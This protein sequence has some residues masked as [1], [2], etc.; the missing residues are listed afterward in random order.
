INYVHSNQVELTYG[1]TFLKFF[2]LP[3]PRSI[4]P[5]KPDSMIDIYTKKFMPEFRAEGGSYPII[6][7]S[8][9]FWNFHILGLF[10]L[11]FIFRVLNNFYIKLIENVNRNVINVKTIFLLFMYVTLIQFVRGSGLEIWLLYGILTIP[12]AIAI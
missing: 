11:Y 4:F 1:S 3:L 10:F 7:Y 9:V 2:F 8:E 6:I 12:M 5:Y